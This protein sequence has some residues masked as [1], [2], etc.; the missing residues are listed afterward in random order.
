M[1]NDLWNCLE[2]SQFL[3]DRDFV[4]I[5]FSELNDHDDGVKS[6]FFLGLFDKIHTDLVD[7]RF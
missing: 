2:T 7:V 1:Q 6:S 3:I 5:I 4:K